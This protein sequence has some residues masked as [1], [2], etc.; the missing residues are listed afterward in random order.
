MP[1]LLGVDLALSRRLGRSLLKGLLASYMLEPMHRIF[2]LSPAKTTGKR[3]QLLLSE[4]ATFDLAHRLRSEGGVTLGEAFS[5]M[6]GL[7]FRGKL[8]YAKRFGKPG[9]GVE[10]CHVITSDAGLLPCETLITRER[11]ELF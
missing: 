8:A 3:A 10:G 4:R 2:I 7:Y 6:S 11:L 1:A 9:P 5:F